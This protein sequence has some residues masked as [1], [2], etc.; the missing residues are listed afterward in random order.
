M[1]L[2]QLTK[3]NLVTIIREVNGTVGDWARISKSDLIERVE[4]LPDRAVREVLHRYN[5]MD[6]VQTHQEGPQRAAVDSTTKDAIR[7]LGE[8]LSGIGRPARG[9]RSVR[10]MI[11]VSYEM[12][13]GRELKFCGEYRE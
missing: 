7:H 2:D 3:K 12:A 10:A 8:R 1:H 13:D 5:L 9:V 4:D 6:A 11:R